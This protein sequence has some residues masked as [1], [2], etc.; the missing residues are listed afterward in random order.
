VEIND[1][2]YRTG[3][4]YYSYSSISPSLCIIALALSLSLVYLLLLFSVFFYKTSARFN[5]KRTPAMGAQ[6]QNTNPKLAI[7]KDKYLYY[8]Q[9]QKTTK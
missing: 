7:S 8:K 2:I 9:P 4:I 1:A 5:F 6:M 3:T